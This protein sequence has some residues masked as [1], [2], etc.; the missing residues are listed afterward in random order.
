MGVFQNIKNFLLVNLVLNEILQQLKETKS[1][2]QIGVDINKRIDEDEKVLSILWKDKT[3][4]LLIYLKG[5]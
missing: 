2:R 1:S 3:H 4:S 5:T